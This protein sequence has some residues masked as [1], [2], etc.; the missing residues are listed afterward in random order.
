MARRV[1]LACIQ[2]VPP[3]PFAVCRGSPGKRNFVKKLLKLYEE[4]WGGPSDE[5]EEEED[6]EGEHY[7]QLCRSMAWL[8]CSAF[9]KEVNR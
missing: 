3:L 5:E 1:R 2:I 7:H 9:R 4:Q 8:S 6:D